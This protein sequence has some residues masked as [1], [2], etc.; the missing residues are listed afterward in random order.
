MENILIPK[1]KHRRWFPRLKLLWKPVS[2]L[3]RFKFDESAKYSIEGADQQDWNKLTGFSRGYHKKNSIRI[4]W[5]WNQERGVLQICDYSYV[6]KERKI[7]NVQDI[8]IG[9]F[10]K[11]TLSLPKG[12]FF[13]LGYML[14]P[15]FGGNKKAPHNIRVKFDWKFS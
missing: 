10:Y 1:N 13:I 2:M 3:V 8:K 15:Y 7:S 4:G 11:K 5:R 6:N 12:K 14:W 9:V